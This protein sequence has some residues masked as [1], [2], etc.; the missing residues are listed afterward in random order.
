MPSVQ[1]SPIT[2][3]AKRSRWALAALV[4]ALSASVLAVV[5]ASV[6]AQGPITTSTSAVE[7][8]DGTYTVP[9]DWPL[10][11]DNLGPG[12]KFRLL[13]LTRASRHAGAQNIEVYDSF[14]QGDADFGHSAI[15]GHSSAYR[16]VASTPT[17][18]A[19]DHLK[20][21]PSDVVAPV[22]WLGG[23]RVSQNYGNTAGEGFWSSA[24]ENWASS[25]RRESFGGPRASN[26]RVWTG[27]NEDGTK[28]SAPLGSPI[29]IVSG[30]TVG[31]DGP[32]NGGSGT[33]RFGSVHLPLYGI[34]PVYVIGVPLPTVTSVSYQGDNT[35]VVPHDWALN[36]DGV[37][38]GDKFR[39]LFITWGLRG[40]DSSNIADYDAHV[41]AAAR[42]GHVAIRGH[43]S[44]YKVV[45]STQSVS[46]RDHARLSST[47]VVAP[48]YWLNG[49]R[50]SQ[51]YSNVDGVGFW[52]S[53]W[54]HYDREHR[55]D[56]TGT[57]PTGGEVAT[58]TNPDGSSHPSEYLGSSLFVGIGKVATSHPIYNVDSQ[59]A[60]NATTFYGISPVYVVGAAPPVVS[61]SYSGAAS[62][63]EGGSAQFTVSAS[64]APEENIQVQLQLLRSQPFGSQITGSNEVTLTSSAPSA[65]VTVT[66]VDDSFYHP[67]GSFTLVLLE[68][69]GY[70]LA[71]SD[72]APSAQRVLVTNNDPESANKHCS[73]D[74]NRNCTSPAPGYSSANKEVDFTLSKSE[75]A[76]AEGE[77]R[78]VVVTF[79]RV[80]LQGRLSSSP[81]RGPDVSRVF[82]AALR[83]DPPQG[84]PGCRGFNI[85][86]IPNGPITQLCFEAHDQIWW[87][88]RPFLNVAVLDNQ[89]LN[90][91]NQLRVRVTARETDTEISGR[92]E[93]LVR[94]YVGDARPWPGVA[95]PTGWDEPGWDAHLEDVVAYT[96]FS[97]YQIRPETAGDRADDRMRLP[98]RR[99][100][101][102]VLNN[103][104]SPDD[105]VVTPSCPLPAS[106]CFSL[107]DGEQRTYRVELSRRPQPGRTYAV[108]PVQSNKSSVGVQDVTFDPP[109]LL[110]THDSWLENRI[111]TVTV[112]APPD[113]DVGSGRFVI[114]H[115]FVG[116]VGDALV[117]ATRHSTAISANVTDPD[118][119]RLVFKDSDGNV[120]SGDHTLT[121]A[122]GGSD[123]YSVEMSHDPLGGSRTLWVKSQHESVK[124]EMWKHPV[125]ISLTGPLTRY[126]GREKDFHR[127]TLYSPSF[128][129]TTRDTR[130]LLW[131]QPQ[132]IYVSAWMDSDSRFFDPQCRTDIDA[133]WVIT[134]EYQGRNG[135]RVIVNIA[136]DETADETDDTAAS[137]PVP[138][139][140]VPASLIADV[141]GYAAETSN[142]DAHVNRWKRVLLAFGESV[143]G[144]AGTPMTAAEATQHAQT[145]WSVRWDPVAA[146]LT[147]LEAAQ[148]AQAQSQQQSTSTVQPQTDTTDTDTQQQQ[149]QQTPSYTVPAALIADV[150]GYAAET[151]NGDAHVNRWRRVLLAFGES[152]PGFGGAPMT[153]A[154]ATQHAQTFW[155]VRW[156][157]VAAALTAL[158][159]Q[160]VPSTSADDTSSNNNP[161]P[162]PVD[163]PS[164]DPVP[165]DPVVVDPVV[166]VAAGADITEGGDAVFTL[167]ASPAP[168][169]PLTVTVDVSA[170]GGYG[171]VTGTSTVTVPTSGTATLTVVTTDD[172]T[173]ETDGSVTA[174]ITDGTGYDPD[175]S[176]AT[177]TV[178]VA[179]DDD[180]PPPPANLSAF[181]ITDGVYTEGSDGGYYLFFVTLDKPVNKPTQVRYTIETTGSGAGHATAGDDFVSA[182]RMVYFRPNIT[183]NAG[184]VVVTDDSAQEPDETFR[185]VLSDPQGAT[186]DHG[187]ATVTIKDND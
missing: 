181:S 83:S 95:P 82:R 10:T 111:Q 178:A 86:G 7:N 142:G 61:V 186:I 57:R 62:I 156:D 108:V 124:G 158:E 45:G 173:D 107:R 168:A 12:D 93:G 123:W 122:P 49:E 183:L 129:G 2:A 21:R 110:W 6:G 120:I 53:Q 76:L 102:R 115:R 163:P 139:Y 137:D 87:D 81:F 9:Q 55:L 187:S 15:R 134:N 91:H 131:N 19:R 175:T 65:T 147:S 25:D 88:M 148:A 43:A 153:A 58:G 64:P 38:P 39:L 144:F 159:A 97:L 28:A 140:T 174:T 150:Q 104:L 119:A 29:N 164:V 78:E 184:V 128:V 127:I 162:P 126:T 112:S 141:Q 176:A 73:V 40:A 27:T 37:Q 105:V 103:D 166:S 34:S 54:E 182:S 132:K 180:P 106:S 145:F 74:R 8:N 99:L 114:S 17:L 47:D 155:S 167:T 77:S 63:T 179:D 14:V 149:Q 11:P 116:F 18:D 35:Y 5:P 92:I 70:R 30:G 96:D 80:P 154:E 157:P 101:V 94:P 136:A 143:P 100:L 71:H 42:G 48:I 24:W 160:A 118:V 125:G 161:N 121:L 16:A 169:A 52:S 171:A 23:A 60:A 135:P 138:T 4:L 3:P 44:A 31:S 66:T 113:D 146:A 20:M 1:Q 151:N 67:D 84:S 33:P 133:C 89:R 22:Y 130:R 109:R 50:V 170:S 41:Q 51:D 177:A 36:P 75:F 72:A 117:N 79:S 172:S 26:Q 152:V 13:F 68:G 185:V 85:S 90:S 69:E 165:I 46:A 98:R 32:I 59:L 56:E